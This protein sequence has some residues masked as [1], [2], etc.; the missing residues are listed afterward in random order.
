M[1]TYLVG[2]CVRDELLGRAVNDRDWV[3]VGSSEDEM[4][5]LGFKRVG[6][7]FPVFLHPETGEEYALARTERKVGSGHTGFQT[8]CVGVSLEED[9][10]R[11]DFTINAMAYDVENDV[12]IDPF[13]GQEDLKSRVIRHVGPAFREDP[14]RVMR[15]ARFAACLPGFQIADETFMLAEEMVR[16]GEL[17]Q[18][19]RERLAAEVVKTLSTCSPI[20]AYHFFEILSHMRVEQHVDFFAEGALSRR[21][22]TEGGRVARKAL[23][24]G[25]DRELLPTI[26]ACMMY[27]EPERAAKL[28]NN[29]S[30]VRRIMFALR[31]LREASNTRGREAEH[32]LQIIQTAGPAASSPT[33][34]TF[35]AA[36]RVAESLGERL[37][38]SADEMDIAAFCTTIIRRNGAKLA[39][40]GIPGD[41]IGLALRVEQLEFLREF[42]RRNSVYKRWNNEN[43]T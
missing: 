10:A 8:D 1:K 30:V 35:I 19:P 7:S 29:A 20:G 6:A 15:M 32:M 9:L 28:S 42:L 38:Y 31:S 5:S 37:T 40:Q 13:G 22:L 11:R 18:L 43:E 4:L 41:Q 16:G 24:L 23:Q 39:E 21:T 36:V 17:Q 25:L 3:V 12:I 34:Q 33:W 26:V 27:D 14:L 2:G